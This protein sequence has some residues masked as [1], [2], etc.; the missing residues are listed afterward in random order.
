MRAV[1][2]LLHRSVM[3][4]VNIWRRLGRSPEG[5]RRAWRQREQLQ[6]ILRGEEGPR[7][8]EVAPAYVAVLLS[9]AL[10]LAAVVWLWV[11]VGWWAALLAVLAGA[12]G[13]RELVRWRR[14]AVVERRRRSVRFGL[15]HVD[16]ADD[17]AF[18]RIVGR[19]L[20]RDGWVNVRGVLV[21]PGLVHLVGDGPDGR[22]VGVA[23]DRGVEHTEQGSGG[24]AALRPV[25]PVLPEGAPGA[26]A[27]FL[28]VSSGTFSRERVVWAARND[29]RLVDRTLLERWAAGEHLA[30]LLGLEAEAAQRSAS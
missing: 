24:R 12:W 5:T 3:G 7:W 2:W 18:R 9:I 1:W 11:G 4:V 29:V 26:E 13:M 16:A 28:V 17:R 20:Q 6:V 19:L 25:A 21:R 23:F 30:A 27:L 15:E 22:P 8:W 14:A 10:P